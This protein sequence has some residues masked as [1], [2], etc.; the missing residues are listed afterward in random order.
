[1]PRATPATR[2]AAAAEA[3]NAKVRSILG[4]SVKSVHT[5]AAA[6]GVGL[7]KY[8][9]PVMVGVLAGCLMALTPADFWLLIA[10]AAVA[11]LR[12]VKIS[13]RPLGTL[14]PRDGLGSDVGRRDPS[15]VDVPPEIETWMRM[16]RQ[17][18]RVTAIY[19]DAPPSANLLLYGPT[20]VGK[21]ASLRLLSQKHGYSFHVMQA[22]DFA[23]KYVGESEKNVAEAFRVARL[24][25]ARTEKP[26]ILLFDEIDTTL[27]KA[28][29]TG[30]DSL[31][32]YRSSVL[33]E[34]LQQLDGGV[35]SNHN[36]F[37]AA[38]TNRPQELDPAL[39]S[40]F[41]TSI[42]FT[43]PSIRA[44]G[45]FF[46]DR[47]DRFKNTFTFQEKV[48]IVLATDGMSYRDLDRAVLYNAA[49]G[50]ASAGRQAVAFPDIMAAVDAWQSRR[51]HNEKSRQMPPWAESIK[52]RPAARA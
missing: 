10:L 42:K 40:R 39:E 3:G 52:G 29:G 44:R 6:L 19:P 37:V 34:F 25:A 47:F 20:G 27:G 48:Q 5:L 32:Q 36:V 16:I 22:S 9:P 13:S 38:A 43:T 15:L 46:R 35:A 50:A 8:G 18:E 12:K 7:K 31:A 23:S 33:G 28:R 1:M 21:T 24:R 14:G 41:N 4:A 30:G 26:V 17:P 49:H 2:P 45:H 51:R 11:L